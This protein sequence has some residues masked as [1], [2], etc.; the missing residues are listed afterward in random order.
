LASPVPER[1][2]DSDPALE[3]GLALVLTLEAD[4]HLAQAAQVVLGLARAL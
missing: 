1:D 3:T 2:P 4:L